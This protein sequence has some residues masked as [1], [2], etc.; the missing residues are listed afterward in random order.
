MST[1]DSHRCSTI[2]MFDKQIPDVPIF[3]V[4]VLDVCLKRWMLDP[5]FVRKEEEDFAG[6]KPP[7]G[8]Y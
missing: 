3:N 4:S 5:A 1:L 7:A 2:V 8:E 6:A